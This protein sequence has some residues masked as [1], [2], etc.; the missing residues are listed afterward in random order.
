MPKIN[1][2]SRSNNFDTAGLID[3]LNAYTD[4]PVLKTSDVVFNSIEIDTIFSSG[5]VVVGGDLTVNGQ[6]TIISSEILEIVDNIILINSAQNSPGVSLNLA[7]V[8]VD[9]GD[10]INFQSV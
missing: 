5:D 7:G 2:Y 8:E 3:I 1:A 9:R 6:T 4:Q 10:L